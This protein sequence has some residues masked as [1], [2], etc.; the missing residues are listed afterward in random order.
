MK[1]GS[2]WKRLAERPRLVVGASTPAVALGQSHVLILSSPNQSSGSH[3]GGVD[4]WVGGR[5]LPSGSLAYHT[6]TDTWIKPDDSSGILSGIPTESQ[7]SRLL[8]VEPLRTT[9]GLA[10]LDYLML[11][12]YLAAM[13][14]MGIGFSKRGKSTEDFFFAGRRVPWWATGMSLFG[15][16]ISAISFMAIPAL[17]YRTDWIYLLGNLTIIAMPPVYSREIRSQRGSRSTIG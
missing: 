10:P 1:P 8:W 4:G 9:A 7:T 15:T 5:G 6:I 16:S 14:V 11:A 17:V 12:V 13:I 3:Q 2:G